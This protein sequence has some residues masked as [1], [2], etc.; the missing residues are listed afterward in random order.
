MEPMRS[1]KSCIK[2]PLHSENA[3]ELSLFFPERNQFAIAIR[4]N[5]PLFKTASSG[6]R[7]LIV[8]FKAE[9]FKRTSPS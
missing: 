3:D 2:P 6:E 7:A 4:K 8:P 1:I 5:A 9:F